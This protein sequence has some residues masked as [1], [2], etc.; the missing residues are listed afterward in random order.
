MCFTVS[1]ERLTTRLRGL[2]FKAILRQEIG[3]FDLESNST[4]ILTVRLSQD[5]SRVQG[6]SGKSIFGG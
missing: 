4:G 1:G 6:V 5:A 2:T 3:W